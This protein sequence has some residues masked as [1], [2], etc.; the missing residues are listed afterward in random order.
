MSPAKAPNT[1]R[2]VAALGNLGFGNAGPGSVGRPLRQRAVARFRRTAM[3]RRPP[4]GLDERPRLRQPVAA[5]LAGQWNARRKRAH[6]RAPG[7]C[8]PG[9]VGRQGRRHDPAERPLPR[10][11]RRRR[12]GSHVLQPGVGLL[13]VYLALYGVTIDTV[14]PTVTSAT[15]SGALIS[16]NGVASSTR[17]GA[18]WRQRAPRLDV[19]GGAARRLNAGCPGRVTIG[20]GWQRRC[21]LEWPDERG[22]GRQRWACRLT[23]S[24]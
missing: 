18:P 20:R 6:Q 24:P 4:D 15:A 13:P 10:V 12:R 21:R 3:A 5:G 22:R 11:A 2:I 19:R 23:L 9:L 8:E 14:A 17:S 1:T 16:P 7:R